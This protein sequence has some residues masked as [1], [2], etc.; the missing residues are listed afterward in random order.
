MTA[1]SSA[2][3]ADAKARLRESARREQDL[4]LAAVRAG[5]QIDRAR[6]RERAAAR[7]ASAEVAHAVRA[8]AD[9]VAKLAVKVGDDRA[10]F[11]L[12]L[13]AKD[14]QTHRR[15]AATKRSPTTIR[16]ASTVP[17]NPRPPGLT[18]PLLHASGATRRPP[19]FD[20]AHARTDVDDDRSKIITAK[21]SAPA[22]SA[23]GA[24]DTTR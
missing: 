10:A 16:T 20:P 9:A 22:V 2:A 3:Q 6:D 21:A 12:G 17:D 23:A 5:E 1:R 13:T 4:M 7:A 18:G 24:A 15:T 19:S 8:H 11:V 14:I